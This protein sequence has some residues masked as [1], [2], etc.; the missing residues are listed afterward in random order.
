VD[1][2]TYDTPPHYEYEVEDLEVGITDK[3][4]SSVIVPVELLSRDL[5]DRIDNIIDS[6]V[7]D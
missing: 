6:K 1:E 4:G 5:R 7:W 3:Y 2:G